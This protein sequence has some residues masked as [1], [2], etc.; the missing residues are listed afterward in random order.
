MHVEMIILD[1]RLPGWGFPHWGSTLAAGLDLHACLDTPMTLRP[2]DPPA[3][4]S[5][6]IALRIG[7]PGWCGL[8]APRSGF[9]H[10]GLVLGNTIGVI[11][12]DYDGPCLL[13]LWNR[14]APQAGEPITIA[15]GERIAQLLLVPV[16]RPV[17]NVVDRFTTDSARGS[18]GFGSTGHGPVGPDRNPGTSAP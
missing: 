14:N 10:R 16:A 1:P 18:G 17:F 11:D 6:G 9:G 7:E 13:S 2:G 8:V 5:S 12:A 15:P 4:V 3:L